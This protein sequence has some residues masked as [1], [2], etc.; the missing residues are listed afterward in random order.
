MNYYISDLHFGWTNRRDNK[1]LETDNLIIENWNKTVTNGDTVYILGDIGKEGGSADQEK[2]I[3]KMAI[4]KGKK[5]LVKGNHEKLKDI[6]LKQIFNEI[7]DYKE[8]SDNIGG[9]NYNVVLSHYPILT[10]NNQ[11]KGWIHLYGHV[12]TSQEWDVYKQSLKLLNKYFKEMR[13][14]EGRTDCPDA[15]AYNVGVMIP[16]MDWTPKTL[17]E[18]ILKNSIDII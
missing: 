18:I 15:V 3:Q 13:E 7:C 6:R 4:L 5:V 9:I 8:V 17:K 1:T 16:Y 11:H 12:H 10:W 14:M 2:L